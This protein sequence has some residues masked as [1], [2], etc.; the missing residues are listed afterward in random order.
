MSVK[1]MENPA[2]F[3]INSGLLFEI[4]RL[5]LHPY[6]LALAVSEGE[7]NEG[8][9]SL[10]DCRDDAEGVL[11]STEAF[12]KGKEKLHNYRWKQGGERAIERRLETIGY[13]IQGE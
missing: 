10:W 9:I 1:Y 6:G 3:L 13:I 11:F 12:A 2:E 7:G 5:V 8:K 4:N